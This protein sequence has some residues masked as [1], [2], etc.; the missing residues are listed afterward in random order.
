MPE[1]AV[2]ILAAAAVY[3]LAVAI[4]FVFYWPWSRA[5]R[6]LRRLR[7]HAAAV[8]TLRQSEARALRLI[9]FP[10][11]APVYL[12]EGSCAEFIIRS[13]HPPAQHVHTLAGVPVKYPANLE[14][15]KRAGRNTAD[16]VL[17][18]DHAMIVRL[19]GTK[20]TP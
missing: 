6:A 20:L 15:A 11:G 9:E 18:R 5:Q 19:N 16:V 4:Y 14:H 17:G 7:Q 12:L 2:W 10:P 8:R 13:R 3:V 1:T